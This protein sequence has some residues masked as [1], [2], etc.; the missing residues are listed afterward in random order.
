MGLVPPEPL[1]LGVGNSVGY[2]RVLVGG[3]FW[4]QVLGMLV[5]DVV[6]RGVRT[7]VSREMRRSKSWWWLKAV[8]NVL[9][10]YV[11]FCGCMPLFGEA[12]RHLGWWRHWLVPVS[13]VKGLRG[14]GWIAWEYLMR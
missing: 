8:G 5:E 7:V 1:H 14:E 9:W 3:F 6:G 4:V 12:G 10:L 13:F 11:W 2:V